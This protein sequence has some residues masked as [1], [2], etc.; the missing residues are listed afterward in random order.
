MSTTNVK[1]N[2]LVNFLARHAPATL[3]EVRTTVPAGFQPELVEG[4][5]AGEQPAFLQ[6][7][8]KLAGAAL[9][10][11]LPICSTI[12]TRTNQR[13]QLSRLIRTGGQIGAAVSAALTT[14]AIPAG[15]RLAIIPAVV[16]LLTSLAA[17][18]SDA[19]VRFSPADKSSL[20]DLYNSLRE[21]LYD[22]RTKRV[23]LNLALQMGDDAELGQLITSC[24][25]LARRLN[26]LIG[27]P[28]VPAKG[29]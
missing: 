23:E 25:E 10:E 18:I 6:E 11:M 16:A 28:T 19:L 17:L 14:A 29:H 8:A 15:G 3:A 7:R 1:V 27:D 22:A 24:N 12:L 9:D 5:L 2:E 20:L 26:L 13:L 4:G 21:D